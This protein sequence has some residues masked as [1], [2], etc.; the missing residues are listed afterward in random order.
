MYLGIESSVFYKV[1]R[2]L[3]RNSAARIL[4][5]GIEYCSVLQVSSV[6]IPDKLE[7]CNNL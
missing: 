5:L 2:F 6:R 4:K 1:L 7:I 3:N